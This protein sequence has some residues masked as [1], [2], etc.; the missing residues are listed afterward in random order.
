MVS[1]KVSDA[2]GRLTAAGLLTAAT[3]KIITPLSSFMICRV[4]KLNWQQAGIT[5]AVPLLL[6]P[7]VNIFSCLPIRIFNLVTAALI[8]LLFIQIAGNLHS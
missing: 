1:W 7:M 4:R 8:I 6:M 5:T 2:T 3:L